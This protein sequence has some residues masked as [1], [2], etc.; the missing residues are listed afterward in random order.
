MLYTIGIRSVQRLITMK[1]EKGVSPKV[2]L[3]KLLLDLS[4]LNDQEVEALGRRLYQELYLTSGKYGIHNAHDGDKIYFREDRFKHAFETAKEW[5]LSSNKD[6]IDKSRIVRIKWIKEFI[7][8]NVTNTECWA[9]PISARALKRLYTSFAK[10]YVVWLLPRN[11]GG[12]KFSTAYNAENSQI[13]NY[14]RVKGARRI[15]K[16]GQNKSP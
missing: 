11:E 1:P 9:I 14:I 3:D 12:W 6:V 5:R 4:G 8:G 13:R 15:W 7:E 2:N 10:G 16:Y